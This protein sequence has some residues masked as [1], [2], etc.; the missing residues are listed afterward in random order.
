MK[1]KS[2]YS[3]KQAAYNALWRYVNALQHEGV[4]TGALIGDG[5]Y[6]A[7]W[8]SNTGRTQWATVERGE[9]DKWIV[10]TNRQLKQIRLKA[11][12]TQTHSFL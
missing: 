7:Q 2:F 4:H 11:G 3:S 12:L 5:G 8:V 9:H 1:L 6:T 10:R